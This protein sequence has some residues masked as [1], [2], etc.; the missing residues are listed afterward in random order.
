MVDVE[1]F[2]IKHLQF[3]LKRVC[4]YKTEVGQL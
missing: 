3:I 2:R 1:F 4:V